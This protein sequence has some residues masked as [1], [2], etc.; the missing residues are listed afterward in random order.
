MRSS[1]IV[2]RAADGELCT[3]RPFAASLS[4]GFTVASRVVVMVRFVVVVVVVVTRPPLPPA[5]KEDTDS[6]RRR[7][8]CAR[9]WRSATRTNMIKTKGPL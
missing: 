6:A 4:P 5:V 3:A 9:S 2:A 8:F 7:S 1:R